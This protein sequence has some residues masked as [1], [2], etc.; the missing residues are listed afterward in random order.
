MMNEV[1][2]NKAK[3]LLTLFLTFFKI[4]P[5]EDRPG[6][7]N[8]RRMT[9]TENRTDAFASVLFFLTKPMRKSMIGITNHTYKGE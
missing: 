3:D 1:K 2:L 9:Y 8:A 5:T 7:R 6:L 4:G